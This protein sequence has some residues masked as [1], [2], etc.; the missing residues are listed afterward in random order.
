MRFDFCWNDGP[1]DCILS[2]PRQLK[3][4][5]RRSYK[6]GLAAASHVRPCKNVFF[7]LAKSLFDT[8]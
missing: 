5:K 7:R 3:I 2:Q 6:V 4:G 8:R 1:I